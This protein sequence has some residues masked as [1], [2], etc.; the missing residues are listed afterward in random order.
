MSA[1]AA[2]IGV[3]NFSTSLANTISASRFYASAETIFLPFKNILYIL[4]ALTVGMY[5]SISSCKSARTLYL[6]SH[7]WMP[8]FSKSSASLISRL[9]RIVSGVWY[10]T[11]L[12]ALEEEMAQATRAAANK[13][14]LILGTCDL[15]LIIIIWQIGPSF[16]SKIMSFGGYLSRDQNY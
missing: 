5:S 1:I 3:Y 16:E 7:P 9:K 2:L 8:V 6:Y 10:G 11:Y 15:N 14:N 4:T 12:T 13:L